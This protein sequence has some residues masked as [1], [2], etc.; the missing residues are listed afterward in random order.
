MRRAARVQIGAHQQNDQ[1]NDQRNDQ[2]SL[3]ETFGAVYSG[4]QVLLQ[5]TT[6]P[7]V[8]SPRHQA[9]FG[10]DTPR[11]SLRGVRRAW[12]RARGRRPAT[13]RTACALHRHVAAEQS[14]TRHDRGP[15]LN[16]RATTPV[17]NAPL[18]AAAGVEA[19]ALESTI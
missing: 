9:W 4:G 14:K 8:G 12:L 7:W 6:D 17:L 2:C 15:G 11:L 19:F 10:G 16:C 3:Y 1:Q 5:G 18:G 13:S